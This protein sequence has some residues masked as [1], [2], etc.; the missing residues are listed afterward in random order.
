[1]SQNEKETRGGKRVLN[2]REYV[3]V[4][5]TCSGWKK[6]KAARELAAGFNHLYGDIFV[7]PET[8]ICELKFGKHGLGMSLMSCSTCKTH[9]VITR[10]HEE[11]VEV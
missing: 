3:E 8:H 9:H 11:D 5:E 2:K 6:S 4:E 1:M 10:A 7:L